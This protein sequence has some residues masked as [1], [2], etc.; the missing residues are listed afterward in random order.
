[1]HFQNRLIFLFL[2]ACSINSEA[3]VVIRDRILKEKERKINT[4]VLNMYLSD[5]LYF[6]L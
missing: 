5:N 4:Q 1:M 3:F 2:K 6:W